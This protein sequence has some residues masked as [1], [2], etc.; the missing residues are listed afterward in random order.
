MTGVF[1]RDRAFGQNI[2][3]GAYM[4][5]ICS[6]ME[7]SFALLTFCMLRFH[8]TY[9]VESIGPVVE[10]LRGLGGLEIDISRFS[11]RC[12]LEHDMCHL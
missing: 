1:L 4:C 7:D 8:Y 2:L 9:L 11:R 5:T 10:R 6:Q 12:F 3:F